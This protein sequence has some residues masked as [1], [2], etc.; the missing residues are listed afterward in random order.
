MTLIKFDSVGGASGDMILAALLDLGADPRTL[1]ESLASLRLEKFDIR[2]TP[3][4]DHALHGTQVEVRV[5]PCEEHPRRLADIRT[6]I[7]ASGL[8]DRVK[9]MS[10]R[11][12]ERLAAAEAKVHDSSPER[13]HFHEVGAVDSIVDVV[14]SCVALNILGVDDVAV[15]PLPLGHG[16]SRCAHGTIPIP[17]P[18][19]LELLKGHP[20]VDTPE[21]F[22]LVTPTGAAILMTWKTGS[23]VPCQAVIT[24][25]ANGFGHR[26][27][28]ERPNL[29]RAFLLDSVSCEKTSTDECM[30]LEC[31]LDDTI[32]ELLGSLTEKLLQRGALDVF[33]TA[34]QMKKQRPGTLLTVLCR[35]SEKDVFSDIIF[36]EST[37]FG[38]RSHS[39]QRNLLQR[40]HVTAKTRYG[41]V[42]IK[43]GSWKGKDITRAPEH[44][45]CVR[46]AR[47]CNVSVRT[48]YEATLIASMQQR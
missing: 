14:G 22:E 32:P 20:V 44:D 1:R 48:V 4:K 27:L 5:S 42:R 41:E 47:A 25:T 45:D 16:F 39:T 26:K 37:T 29:L 31:N 40:R 3:F 35:P 9:G 33:T 23:T 15:G 21:P 34:V 2:N 10:V 24:R 13:I 46:C 12:F 18:A 11:I 38:I 17:A 6:L 30:V 43:M 36:A 8:P 19:T 7:D 28:K